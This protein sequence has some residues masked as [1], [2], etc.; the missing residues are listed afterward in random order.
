MC[1]YIYI[2]IYIYIYLIENYSFK[3]FRHVREMYYVLNFR[4]VLCFGKNLNPS[5]MRQNFENSPP[6]IKGGGVC[7][8]I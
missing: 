5:P 7:Y 2:Y 6:F 1:V 3:N 4:H 8:Y